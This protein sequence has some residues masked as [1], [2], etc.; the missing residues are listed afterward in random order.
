MFSYYMLTIIIFLCISAF[1]WPHHLQTR[2]AEM[3]SAFVNI[4][5]NTISDTMLKPLHHQSHETMT[6]L[7]FW[8]FQY[9]LFR[10][11]RMFTFLEC[12]TTKI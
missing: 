7:Y 10:I 1:L 9:A 2:P 8:T 4:S 5:D 3:E 11:C 6:S 12:N